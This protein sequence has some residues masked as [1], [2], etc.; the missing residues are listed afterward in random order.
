MSHPVKTPEPRVIVMSES[1]EFG[2]ELI[3]ER[4]VE[5]AEVGPQRKFTVCGRGRSTRL[6]WLSHVICYR[7]SSSEV[8]RSCT[9]KGAEVSFQQPRLLGSKT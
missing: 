1:D 9:G 5:G 3:Q 6:R 8:H 4:S 2:V 7:R